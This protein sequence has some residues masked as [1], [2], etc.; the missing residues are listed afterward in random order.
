[1][2]EGIHN[3]PSI[4]PKTIHR[5]LRD[6]AGDLGH[7]DMGQKIRDGATYAREMKVLRKDMNESR[8]QR[9]L[10]ADGVYDEENRTG[11]QGQGHQYWDASHK[12]RAAKPL[13]SPADSHRTGNSG[14]ASKRFASEPSSADDQ[15]RAS[16][17]YDKDKLKN[18]NKK[19]SGKKPQAPTLADFYKAAVEKNMAE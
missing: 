16:K 8:R 17:Y 1:M 7:D 15:Y 5:S 6:A 13:G 2:L 11:R 3:A 9:A 14:S 10:S 18:K 12:G 19:S 4:D